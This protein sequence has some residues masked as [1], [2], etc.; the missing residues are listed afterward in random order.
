MN[1]P[2]YDL[3]EFYIY[4]K[5]SMLNFYKKHTFSRPL[6]KWSSHL[7]T[8]KKNKEYKNIQTLIIKIISL[9][10]I[11]LMRVGDEYNSSILNSNIIRFNRLVINDIKMKIDEDNNIIFLLFRIFMIFSKKKNK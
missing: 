9:F 2:D 6:E 3:E 11:D 7:N 5:K 10:A 8:L 1:D 4:F